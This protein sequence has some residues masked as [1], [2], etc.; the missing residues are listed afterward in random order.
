MFDGCTSLTKAPALPATTLA[1]YCYGMMFQNCSSLSIAP[2]LP[3]TTLARGCYGSMFRNCTNLTTAPV[4]PA[5]TL[6]EACY[7]YMFN[8]CAR[9]S[10]LKA[11]FL[12]NLSYWDEY[13]YEHEG[14]SYSSTQY[15]LSG[16]SST[17]TLVLHKN[18]SRYIATTSY[19][20]AGCPTGWTWVKEVECVNL[21]LSMKWATT[22]IGA[23]APEELGSYYAWGE[24]N[25]KYNYSWST[26]RFG[27]GSSFSKYNTSSSYGSV[28]N[29]KVL[30]K[31]DDIASIEYGGNWRMPTDTEWN[32]LRTNCSWTWTTI[33]GVYGQLA[34][35]K[36]NG[37]SIFFPATGKMNGTQIEYG[38]N[39]YYWSS[40]LTTNPPYCANCFFIHS[41]SNDVGMS[42]DF[43]FLGLPVR[44]V[45]N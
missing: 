33:N 6:A 44:P 35:S 11:L 4:L 19:Q 22:N 41:N 36:I 37:N 24:Y 14:E 1:D 32:E 20:E 31:G 25:T 29:K 16:V 34:T 5:A 45:V 12:Q 2:E 10:Y 39:G 8:G 17:G 15:W 3:A 18:A 13:D 38:S 26:Y 30:E 21:G 28:D 9:L 27:D 40:N 23:I 7:V 42:F 43:R